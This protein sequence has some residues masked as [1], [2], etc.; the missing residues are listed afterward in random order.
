[1]GKAL[2]RLRNGFTL[3]GELRNEQ[4]DSLPDDL[5]LRVAEDALPRRVEGADHALLVDA[6]HDVLDVIKN[7]LQMLR[8][9]LPRL[10]RERARLIGHEAKGFH[11][12]ARLVI[13]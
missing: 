11:V 9:L 6:Q 1:G 8:A 4:I 5:G 10:Q 3:L 12:T 13:E 7:D 2:Q